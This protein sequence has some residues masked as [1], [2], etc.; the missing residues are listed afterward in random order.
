MRRMKYTEVVLV[1]FYGTC[2]LAWML[3][4]LNMQAQLHPAAGFWRYVLVGL[5]NVIFCPL[6]MWIAI[7]RYGAL[8]PTPR[9]VRIA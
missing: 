4:A 9:I 3:H 2:A 1:M 7:V 6:A 8:S 5:L